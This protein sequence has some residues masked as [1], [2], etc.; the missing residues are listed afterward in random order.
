M[1]MGQLESGAELRAYTQMCSTAI[2]AAGAVSFEY[3]NMKINSKDNE[4]ARA[5]YEM[6]E[7]S[8]KRFAIA[9][10][11]RAQAGVDASVVDRDDAVK[12]WARGLL[13]EI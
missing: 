1:G 3:R 4:F 7:K 5:M 10:K 11:N 6:Q 12:S 13:G 8:W 9:L 2:R